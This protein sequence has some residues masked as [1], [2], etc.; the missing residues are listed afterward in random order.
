MRQCVIAAI[1]CYTSFSFVNLRPALHGVVC[2]MELFVLQGQQNSQPLRQY[3]SNANLAAGVTEAAGDVAN[4]N[5]AHASNAGS[6]VSSPRGAAGRN[7]RPRMEQWANAGT[8]SASIDDLDVLMH[9]LVIAW[10]EL[11]DDDTTGVA[12]GTQMDAGFH[13]SQLASHMNAADNHL[14]HG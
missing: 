3:S 8:F 10:F 4:G 5:L 7:V 1:A 13:T 14:V 12:G 6:Q 9:A 2:F 11:I